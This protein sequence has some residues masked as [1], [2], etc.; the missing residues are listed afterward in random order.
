LTAES[1][2]HASGNYG[3]MDQI[4]ALEWVKKNIAAFGG[5]PGNVTI[6]GESAG[7]WA[8]NLLTTSPLAKELFQ[9][10]IGESGANV[11]A[12]NFQP[13]TIRDDAEKAGEKLA[14]GMGASQELLKTL[15]AKPAEELLEAAASSYP[16]AWAIVDSWVLPQDVETI[17]AQGKQNDV[18]IIIGNTANE[19]T[20]LM[21]AVTNAAQF[22]A[23][24]KQR[25]GDMATQFLKAYPADSD[26]QATE[27]A[28]TSSRDGFFAWNMREWARMQTRTG[29]HAAYRYYF[30][31]R[32]P[33][34]EGRQLGAFHALDLAYVFGNFTIFRFPWQDE[35]R[36]LSET[37]MSY[38]TNFANT[39]D[40]NG[41]GVPKWLV[42]NPTEDNVLD[43]ADPISMRRNVDKAGLDFFDAYHDRLASTRSE[44]ADVK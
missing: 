19:F 17:Y 13:M 44:G 32:P 25:Y 36:K 3:L 18:P 33:G 22:V 30:S 40:P 27:S 7:S 16:L 39:G 42:Y 4:A 8:V 21:P 34:S 28:Y 31:H 2:H 6:F 38:W 1:A 43:I 35:D 37:I 20:T 26:A 5:D 10:A 15:R 9:R 11:V 14:R 12:D 23:G 41:P 24:V 29:H